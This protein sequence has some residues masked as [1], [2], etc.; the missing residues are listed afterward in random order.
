M[1]NVDAS[2]HTGANEPSVEECKEQ[3]RRVIRSTTFRNAA[4][5]QLLLQFLTDKTITGSA[6]V[7]KEYTIGVEALGRKPDFDPKIDPI[8]RVQSHRLRVKLKEYYEAEGSGDPI[9][10]Q[11]PKGHYVP[12]FETMPATLPVLTDSSTDKPESAAAVDEVSSE[13]AEEKSTGLAQ[14]G[15]R[16]FF[17][18]ALFAIA[19]MALGYWLGVWHAEK[20]ATT[21]GAA[22]SVSKG[23]EVE[24][25]WGRFLGSDTTPVIAYTDAV[26]LLDDSND[27]FRFRHGAIDSRGALVD[28]HLAREFASNPEIVAKAGQLYY[29]NGYTGTGE[30]ESIAMLAG[31]FGRMGMKPI[32]KSSR[33]VTPEDLNQHNVILLG[34][35]FQ[36]AAVAQLLTAGDFRYNNPDQHHEQWRAQIVND[37]PRAGEATT[38]H[39]E[40]DATTK[41]LTADYSL[42]TIAAGV[43]PGRWI[44]ILGGLDTKGTEGAAMFVT[45]K[46][47]IE[48][49]TKNLSGFGGGKNELIP[50]QALVRVQLAKGYQVLD[51]DLVSVHPISPAKPETSAGTS[52]TP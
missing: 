4:T 15:R 41:V 42:I 28:P 27:L 6:D 29:E 30:L 45:S 26:F 18:L 43:S 13:E 31:L 48:R 17:N 46:H 37:H 38:Y 25:F 47:G 44:A 8:V 11:F 7:L 21:G 12:T 49:L 39:T 19:M 24:S 50:F 5:L 33:D 23:D 9:L 14:T 34:S 51:A 16:L 2:D 22:I 36:N 35:P 52:S 10:I 40:R 32:I 1:A 3:V 20:R